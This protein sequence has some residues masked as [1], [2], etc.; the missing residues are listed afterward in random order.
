MEGRRELE[1]IHTVI[2][3]GGQSGLSVGYHLAR[4]GLPFVILD[5]NAR[6]GDSWRHRW[7]SLRLFTPARFNGLDGWP[8]PAAPDVF[9][10]K[11]E[12]ADYL[13]SYAAHF[14]L[15]VRA[16]T[17]VTKLSKRDGTF[18]VDTDSGSIAADQVVVAMATYQASRIPRLAKELDPSIVQLHSGAYRNPAQL[19]E[20]GVLLVGAGNS[21]AE[22][23]IEVARTHRTW[24]SGRDVGEVPFRI[25]SWVGQHLLAPFVLRVLFHRILTV[26]TPLG[27][28]V[29][30]GVLSRGGPL[31]RTRRSNLRTAGVERVVRVAGVKDGWPVLTDGR[32]MSDV[33]NVIW[34][35]GYHAGFDWIDLPV[36]DEDGEPR[37]ERGLVASEPGLYFVGLHFLYALSS[38]MIHGV[39]RDAS[40]VV[41]AIV[42]RTAE[43]VGTADSYGVRTSGSGL[44]ASRSTETVA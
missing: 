39:G 29:R 33:A 28:K 5:A 20:G 3:G 37:H 19:R 41:D 43:S 14:S 1:R 7:D 16:R 13:E 31:I 35:T 26:N 38:T 8:F 40:R 30:P 18:I 24:M 25:S 27:R 12:M 6:V 15:P 2:I 9:P 11:D 44:Q 42:R 17:R 10:T 23:A 4:R 34:C 22:I 21:G 36:L 32:V